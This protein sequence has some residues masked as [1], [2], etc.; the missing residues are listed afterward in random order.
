MKFKEIIESIPSRFRKDRAA[1]ISL[2]FHFALSG[3]DAEAFT[4]IIQNS[5]CT[6]EKGLKGEPSCI[7]KTSAENYVRLETGELNP[8]LALM[9]GKVKVSN[10]AE[11]I[12]FSKLFRKY[13]A[14]QHKAPGSQKVRPQKQGPLAGL[15]ILDFTHL[16]PGPLSTMLMADM[17]ADVIKIEDPDSPDSIRNFPPFIDNVSAYY[18]SLNRSKR[19]MAINY[20]S[21]A[22]KQTI[23][24]LTKNADILFEQFRPGV[25][26]AMGLGYSDL[27]KINPKLIYVSITGYGQTGPYAQ[28]AGHDLNYIAYSGLLGTTGEKGNAPAIPGGQIADVAGGSY[29]AVNAALAALYARDK[30]GQGQHVDVA[31]LDCVMPLTT[32]QTARY[33]ATQENIE[34]GT[35]ALSGGL[36]NYNVYACADEKYIALGA[37]EP[38]FWDQ[39]CE[40]VN[41]QNWK[42]RILDTGEEMENLKNLVAAVFKTK[43]REEWVRL[44][45]TKDVCIS[46]VLDI[47]EVQNDPQVQH[48]K[49]VVTEYGFPAIGIPVKFSQTPATIAWEAPKLGEDSH[50]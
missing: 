19:S 11:M 36:A 24:Q 5:E 8:Q 20:L 1:G 3:E 31:M 25:M 23:F 29:M 42:T 15:K 50:C 17:G 33:Y 18:L 34:R 44:S 12:R 13:D 9:T 46:P 4:I 28:R 41:K 37:L 47:A 40:M 6:L 14:Q 38:K 16:L 30:T 2:I 10:I 35:F 26:A 49:M 21:E 39:F 45:E 48:R 43:T 32:L 27:I 22:G 7:V